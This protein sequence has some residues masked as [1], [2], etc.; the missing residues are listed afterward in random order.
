MLPFWAFLQRVGLL[1]VAVWSCGQLPGVRKTGGFVW[2]KAD[3]EIV[4]RSHLF[5]HSREIAAK[6]L[7]GIRY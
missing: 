2:T 5:L 4:G 1:D 3:F 7:R 6:R